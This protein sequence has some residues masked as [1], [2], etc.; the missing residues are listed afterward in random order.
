MQ[1]FQGK[2]ERFACLCQDSWAHSI[3]NSH[4]QLFQILVFTF[5]TDS[6]YPH[7][8]P[9]LWKYTAQ[10]YTA[11]IAIGPWFQSVVQWTN[12]KL[13][14]VF[15]L[16]FCIK[17]K[18]MWRYTSLCYLVFWLCPMKD[19]RFWSFSVL[20]PRLKNLFSVF[21]VLNAATKKADWHL[22]CITILRILISAASLNI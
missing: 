6:K 10:C 16:P 15:V 9:W 11:M 4:R 1:N 12:Q 21:E 17:K 3:L 20:K 14:L 5:I 8:P 13:L 19:G 22:H 18:S 2:I 7:L